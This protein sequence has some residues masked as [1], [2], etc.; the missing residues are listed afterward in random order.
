MRTKQLKSPPSPINTAP[1]NQ[2]TPVPTLTLTLA[3]GQVLAVA[4]NLNTIADQ[5]LLTSIVFEQARGT[6]AAEI[7]NRT[8]HLGT[9][10]T[11]GLDYDDRLTTRL[12]CSHTMAYAYLALP[13]GK[14]GLRHR[15]LGKKYIVTEQAVRDFLGDSKLVT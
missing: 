9:K 13:V 3:T 14:G 6:Q 4:L 5:R 7:E 8:Y 10:A 2:S 15:R 1:A 11:P 12:K